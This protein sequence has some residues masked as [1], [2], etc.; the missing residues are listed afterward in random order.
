MFTGRQEV[1]EMKPVET[2]QYETTYPPTGIKP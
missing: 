2:N 1:K